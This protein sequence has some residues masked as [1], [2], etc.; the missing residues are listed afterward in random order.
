VPVSAPRRVSQLTRRGVAALAAVTLAAAA[1]AVAAPA[2]STAASSLAVRTAPGSIGLRLL[3]APITQR[4]DPRAR[5]YV[6]DHLAP[7]TVIHR[8]VEVSNTSAS[9]AGVVLYSAAASI[10]KGSFLGR[11]D[12]PPTSCPPGHP[13]VRSPPRSPPVGG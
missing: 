3:D 4:E 13:C 6:V 7:G 5:I 10:A 1:A 11:P 8:R 12:T 2:A 9:T